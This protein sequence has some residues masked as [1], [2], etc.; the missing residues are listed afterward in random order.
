MLGLLDRE[1][2]LL[3]HLLLAWVAA[4]RIQLVHLLLLLLLD[5]ELLG[6]QG[7]LLL[8]GHVIC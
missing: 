3:V 8:L 2:L 7:L 6:D 5:G 4:V 1:R